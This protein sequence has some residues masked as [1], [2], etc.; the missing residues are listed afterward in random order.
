M[1]TKTVLGIAFILMLTLVFAGA[2]HE[3][4]RRLGLR[5][6]GRR[7]VAKVVR[8]EM[9]QDT[10]GAPRYFPVV[11]FTLPDGTKATAEAPTGTPHTSHGRIGERVTIIYNPRRPT[12]IAIPSLDPGHTGFGTIAAMSI[13]AAAAAHGVVTLAL[14]ITS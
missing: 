8:F 7:T 1:T 13:C 3:I 10:D 9:R 4:W 12:T 11:S 5:I 2:V 6:R 14:E